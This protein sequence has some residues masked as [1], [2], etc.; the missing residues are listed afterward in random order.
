MTVTVSVS[1]T[2]VL[3]ALQLLLPWHTSTVHP[4]RWR[5]FAVHTCI[6]FIQ[7]NFIDILFPYPA[8]MG[9]DVLA[10]VTTMLGPAESRL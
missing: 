2:I 8:W 6:E 7:K 3:L 4:P 10:S 9:G 5:L 1:V